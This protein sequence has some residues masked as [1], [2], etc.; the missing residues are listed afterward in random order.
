MSSSAEP[1]KIRVFRRKELTLS[2]CGVLKKKTS[3]VLVPVLGW[4]VF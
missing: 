1:S 2:R 4:R 3:S